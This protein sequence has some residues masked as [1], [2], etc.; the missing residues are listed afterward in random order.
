MLRAS[1]A[2]RHIEEGNVE[3][4]VW[5]V[6]QPQIQARNAHKSPLLRRL[7]RSRCYEIVRLVID[8]CCSGRK[9][10]VVRG[11]DVYKSLSRR[12]AIGLQQHIHSILLPSRRTCVHKPLERGTMVH[13]KH[14]R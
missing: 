8:D 3:Y 9:K 10:H 13:L 7:S 5:S 1:N 14:T 6:M 2:W 4:K 11:V 12:R